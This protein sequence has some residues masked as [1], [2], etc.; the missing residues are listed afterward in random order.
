[1]CIRDSYTTKEG[2]LK[3]ARPCVCQNV[4][5]TLTP[6][7]RHTHLHQHQFPIKIFSRAHPKEVFRNLILPPQLSS[8]KKKN[9]YRIFSFISYVIVKT[10]FPI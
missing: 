1:M 2:G 3:C 5:E 9:F 8:F 10:L 7:N 6:S 4:L